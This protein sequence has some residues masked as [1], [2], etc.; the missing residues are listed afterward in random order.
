MSLSAAEKV[1][2]VQA[3]DR[4][5]VQFVE[6]GFPS[7]N[8]KEAE[9]FRLLADVELE[10][11]QV[12]AFGMTRRRD[13]SAEEDP[14]LRDLVESA[15]PVVTFV[16]KTAAQDPQKLRPFISPFD[17]VDTHGVPRIDAVSITG[18]FNPSGPG[19]TP[20][21]R[22]VLTCRPALASEEAACARTI[23]TTLAR[24][25][26]RRPT[27]A[28]DADLLMGFFDA[29]RREGGTFEHGIERALVR[30]LTSPEFIFRMERDPATAKPVEWLRMLGASVTVLG[31]DRFGMID[32]DD[33]RKAL[34]PRTRLVSVMHS[35]NE[36]G[37]LMR[38][39][40]NML[41]TV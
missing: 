38:S 20:S 6:A 5:G 25:A 10:Q 4:L 27:T 39:F 11:A 14:A 19:D 2:V 16:G 9:L 41:G 32:P 12:C 33:V 15:A 40:S 31:V 34:T 21:R 29:G 35:N 26:Y 17:A 18:P 22:K 3:L 7:S 36:V 13:V 23:L 28:A 37:T 1:R 24:R 8:P 30:L